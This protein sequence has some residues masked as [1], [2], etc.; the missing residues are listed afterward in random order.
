MAKSELQQALDTIKKYC[1][2][3]KEKS[4]QERMECSTLKQRIEILKSEFLHYVDHI[5]INYKKTQIE[6][7]N[8][9]TFT[10][11]FEEYNQYIPIELNKKTIEDCLQTLHW[12]EQDI[13]ACIAHLKK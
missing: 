3:P 7:E 4:F 9:G 12:F 2:Q 6:K 1:A 11:E 10:G 8:P 13:K 5:T